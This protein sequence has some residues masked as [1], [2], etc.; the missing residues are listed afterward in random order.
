MKSSFHA[1]A[2]DPSEDIAKGTSQMALDSFS[3]IA[4]SSGHQELD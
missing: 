2:A 4:N 3:A 1:S